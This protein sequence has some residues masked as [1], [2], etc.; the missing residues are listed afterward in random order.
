LIDF[1]GHV[2]ILP[3]NKC[4]LLFWS[5]IN[6]PSHRTKDGIADNFDDL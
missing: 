6:S 1:Q 4:S 5:L 2:S 3:E